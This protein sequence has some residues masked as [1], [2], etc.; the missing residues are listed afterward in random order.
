MR[1]CKSEK[2]QG[3]FWRSPISLFMQGLKSLTPL[4]MTQFLVLLAGTAF[5]APNTGHFG[6]F[7]PHFNGNFIFLPISSVLVFIEMMVGARGGNMG[8]V[9][10]E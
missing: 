4:S 3:V 8:A 6:A 10:V 1:F 9:N 5:T 7:E 2:Y